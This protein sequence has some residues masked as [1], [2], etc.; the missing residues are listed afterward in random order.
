V[1][2][3][4]VV[5]ELVGILPRPVEEGTQGPQ[6]T[7]L[8]AAQQRVA[9]MGVGVR[10]QRQHG[11]E[12]PEQVARGDPQEL[13]ALRGIEAEGLDLVEEVLPGDGM[14]HPVGLQELRKPDP[15]P[16][17]TARSLLGLSGPEADRRSAV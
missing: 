3:A 6:A 8:A 14:A 11:V 16:G 10:H 7:V 15:R 2:P 4:E 13:A 9:L 5:A 1:V 17:G 12:V